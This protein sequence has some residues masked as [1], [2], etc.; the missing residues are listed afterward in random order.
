MREIHEMNMTS[1][2]LVSWGQVG[3]QYKIFPLHR[4]ITD[5]QGGLV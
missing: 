3:F 4:S 5:L 2:L 1:E